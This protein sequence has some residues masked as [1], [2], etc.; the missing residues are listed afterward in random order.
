MTALE[1]TA[2]ESEVC[3]RACAAFRWPWRMPPYFRG[4]LADWTAR[5]WPALAVKVRLCDGAELAALY[6]AV[7]RP[8]AGDTGEQPPVEGCSTPRP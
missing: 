5:R 6:D 7:C 8:A 1:I 3:A 4:Y 2:G